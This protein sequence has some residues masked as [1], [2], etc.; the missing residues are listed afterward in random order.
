MNWNTYS[1]QPSETSN[2]TIKLL[3]GPT[4]TAATNAPLGTVLIYPLAI[5]RAHI[6]VKISVMS[7]TRSSSTPAASMTTRSSAAFPNTHSYSAAPID[8]DHATRHSWQPLAMAMSATR[9]NW[10]RRLSEVVATDTNI[11]EVFQ[12]FCGAKFY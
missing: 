5:K 4:I 12:T 2:L 7:R 10:I 3:R 6:K 9:D 1:V 11:K 8:T